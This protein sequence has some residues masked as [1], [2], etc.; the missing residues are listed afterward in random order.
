M[1]TGLLKF[2]ST[3][4]E[5]VVNSALAQPNDASAKPIDPQKE[6]V[7]AVRAM[8][9]LDDLKTTRDSLGTRTLT[10]EQAARERD[11]L[12]AYVVAASDYDR[13]RDAV[14]LQYDRIISG[15]IQQQG[16][17]AAVELIKTL[18]GKDDASTI[19][20]MVAGQRMQ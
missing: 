11:V 9:D 10:V 6:L 17:G 2:R 1:T 5:R 18:Y 7:S 14:L 16:L 4:L 12:D 13:K 20:V 15:V 8:Q 19:A 3:R